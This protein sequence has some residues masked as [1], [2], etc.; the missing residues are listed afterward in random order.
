MHTKYFYKKNYLS[1]WLCKKDKIGVKNIF[2][3]GMCFSFLQQPQK[4][5]FHKTTQ[6]HIDYRDVDANFLLNI[7]DN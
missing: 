2:L 1:F 7:F 6:T 4:I 5:G 3:W